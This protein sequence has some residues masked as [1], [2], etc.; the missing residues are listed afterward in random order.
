[1]ENYDSMTEMFKHKEGTPSEMII[2]NVACR[3]IL[4]SA[5]RIAQAIESHEN[6]MES[7]EVSLRK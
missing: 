5:E 4:W 2:L 7:I 6:I 1:M 3:V